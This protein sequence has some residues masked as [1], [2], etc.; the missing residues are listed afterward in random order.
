M[1]GRGKLKAA[2][3][4]CVILSACLV[5]LSATAEPSLL[6]EDQLKQLHQAVCDSAVHQ[7]SGQEAGG[8]FCDD[9]H[10]Y[11]TPNGLPGCSL[12]F[13]YFF[14][15]HPVRIYYGRFTEDEP[16]A[17]AIYWAS[18]EPHANNFGGSALF[19]VVDGKFQLIRFY[20]GEVYEDCVVGNVRGVPGQWPYCYS[21]YMGQGELTENFGP[22]DLRPGPPHDWK[23]WLTTDNDDGF[24]GLVAT[25]CDGSDTVR[26]LSGIHLGGTSDEVVVEGVY[27]DREGVKKACSR[28]KKGQFNEDEKEARKNSIALR[29]YAILRDDEVRYFKVLIHF[30][31]P[32]KVPQIEFTHI[33]IS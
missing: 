33:P 10:A 22:A 32:S 16:Q 5:S 13:N 19:G 21:S 28:F 9:P 24:F 1:R 12:S 26:R 11:P 31:L 8:W 3:G 30:H 17:L 29:S 2:I 14:A 7:G 18:C 23:S 27:L 15:A 6:P 4:V 25:H 20:P